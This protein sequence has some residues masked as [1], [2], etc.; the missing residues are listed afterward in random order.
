MKRKITDKTTI[1]II[2][3]TPIFESKRDSDCSSGLGF[4]FYG[5]CFS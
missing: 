2:E 3:N 1:S 4:D 5:L